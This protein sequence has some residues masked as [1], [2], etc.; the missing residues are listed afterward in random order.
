MNPYI[1]DI[2]SQPSALRD[3]LQ[4]YSTSDLEDIANRLKRG[5]FDRIIISGMGS[6][7]NAAYPAFLQLA[8]QALPIQLVNSAELL[9]SLN[10]L[11]GPRTLL[12]L[13]SQSGRS[14]ELIHLLEAI[15]DKP[16][17]CV[18]AFVND[19][20]SPL[21][22]GANLSLPIHAGAEATVST[23][24][25]VNMLAVYLLAAIQLSGGN[26]ELAIQD[27]SAASEAMDVY[28][29][30]WQAHMQELDSLLGNFD[31]LFLLGRGASMSAVW[32]GS[33]INKEAAKCAF[34][35]LHSADFR[36]GPLELVSNG[37]IAMIF[38]GSAE[39]LELNRRLGLEIV[40]L[41]GRVLWLDSKPEPQLQT[42]L[43]PITSENSRPLV[44]I[45]P[46]QLLSLVMA[47]R[48][49]IQAGQFRHVGKVTTS[50]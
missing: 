14:A 1:S 37:F 25:Y 40:S 15:Q 7:Y 29:S 18:L 34:E 4:A 24:T 48:K 50:E 43:L 10:G 31:K 44:E 28:L 9:H 35:G 30:G 26:T 21:A 6:S 19:P 47:E 5:D 36:H 3:A 17:A 12:W 2:L 23:K 42:V 13:N 20:A 32:N 45:L 8:K 38:A 16:P 49:G 41:G 11:I 33:L 46:M 39:T 27:L 22:L